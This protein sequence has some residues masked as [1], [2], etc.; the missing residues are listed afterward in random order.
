VGAHAGPRANKIREA[1]RKVGPMLE[2][3]KKELGIGVVG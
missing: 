1:V 2:K 3:V